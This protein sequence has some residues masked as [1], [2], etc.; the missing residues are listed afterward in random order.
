MEVTVV[1]LRR[2][3]VKLSPAQVEAETRHHGFMA[4]TYW[5]LKNGRE[6]R[7]VKELI[8]KA[9][10]GASARP[11]LTLTDPHQTQL[12]GLDMIYTGT[13]PFEGKDYPQAWWM[14]IEAKPTAASAPYAY[15][16]KR[17]MA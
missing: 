15:A 17:A 7:R 11:T 12:K 9:A 3:G 5:H 6:D 8:L 16:G 2:A 13:E 10:E 4:I 14:R 1:R